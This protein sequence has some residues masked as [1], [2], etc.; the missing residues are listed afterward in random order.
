MSIVE[1]SN[2]KKMYKLSI[3]KLNRLTFIK[4]S[5]PEK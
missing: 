4:E 1:F 3:P 5:S 2:E